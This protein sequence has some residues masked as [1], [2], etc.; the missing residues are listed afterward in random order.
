MIKQFG[1][2]SFMTWRATG[3]ATFMQ[4]EV[5]A[6]K[7]Q[8][9]MQISMGNP[10]TAGMV[11]GRELL[12]QVWGDASYANSLALNVQITYLRK[13]LKGDSSVK[14]ESVMKKGYVL[15]G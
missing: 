3:A 15:R 1:K 6:N 11:N 5:L 12:E 9:F 7:L 2:T 8:G 13:A 10:A 14:I 4:K